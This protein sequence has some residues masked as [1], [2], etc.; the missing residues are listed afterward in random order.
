MK[1]DRHAGLTGSLQISIFL[2]FGR[3]NVGGGI[4]QAVLVKPSHPFK[5]GQFQRFLGLPRC[6]AVNGFGLVP[7]VD[8]RVDTCLESE[9]QSGSGRPGLQCRLTLT[10]G[11]VCG[12]IASV[13]LLRPH[14]TFRTS[15][16]NWCDLLMAQSSQRFVPPQ[17]RGDSAHFYDYP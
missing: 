9:T 16:E 10:M 1:S 6:F 14:R 12:H 8:G 13:L 7:A 5:R 4:R 11:R 3:G 15:G 2:S 17:I